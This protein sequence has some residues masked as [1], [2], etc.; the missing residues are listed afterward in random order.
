MKLRI[1]KYFIL[2][3]FFSLMVVSG[4]K[5]APTFSMDNEHDPESDLYQIATPFNLQV[6]FGKDEYSGSADVLKVSWDYPQSEKY[7]TGFEIFRSDTDTTGF[8][9]IAFVSKGSNRNSNNG[10]TFTYLYI[11]RIEYNNVNVWYKI[12]AVYEQTDGIIYAE[13][14]P[15][16]YSANELEVYAKIQP[17]HSDPFVSFEWH[18]S[19]MPDEVK[20]EFFSRSNPDTDFILEHT[21]ILDLKATE[22]PLDV[23]QPAETEYFYKLVLNDIQSDFKPISTSIIRPALILLNTSVFAEN[24][25]ELHIGIEEDSSVVHTNNPFIQNY[26]LEVFY[27]SKNDSSQY[28]HFQDFDG[29]FSAPYVTL[30]VPNLNKENIYRSKLHGYNG[31]YRTRVST[32]TL[33]HDMH[34]IGSSSINDYQSAIIFP[35]GSFNHSNSHFI[36]SSDG[37][38]P[39]IANAIELKLETRLIS[40]SRNDIRV[41]F[42]NYIGYENAIVSSSSNGQVSVWSGPTSHNSIQHIPNYTGNSS[43]AEKFYPVDF[44]VV[45]N[46]EL[47][48]AYGDVDQEKR[49]VDN[50][51]VTLWN[52]Q[53]NTHETVF[54]VGPNNFHSNQF[55]VAFNKNTIAI[56]FAY[57]QSEVKLITINKDD[58]SVKRQT[59]FSQQMDAWDPLD[60][61]FSNNG[62][63]L[64]LSSPDV[65]LQVRVDNH[66]IIS[67]ISDVH[68]RFD[69]YNIRGFATAK[70]IAFTCYGGDYWYHSFPFYS[71]IKCAS[72]YLH[73]AD[74][75]DI[76]MEGYLNGLIM[77]NNGTKLAAIFSEK[78]ILYTFE[79]DWVLTSNYGM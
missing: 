29:A 1:T 34:L 52:A 78:I 11:D 22:F 28:L 42:W 75:L 69:W 70:D 71:Q 40:T 67:S 6:Q 48:I 74:I 77:T 38:T 27:A 21:E 62:K 17:F 13:S 37:N 16:S 30:A 61:H 76:S 55:K 26:N 45:S 64:I 47:V 3:L 33:F 57:N 39:V 7:L 73:E 32:N 51:Y 63:E 66:E 8:E 4:C 5:K 56:L 68:S 35:N 53:E 54:H 14:E 9:E 24:Q 20:I 50:Y 59:F 43:N 44:D 58:F 41:A 23:N 18:Y 65:L 49:T 72:D 12:R 36:F 25:A 2:G 10:E 31:N 19:N 46:K 79:N 60:I 15:Y